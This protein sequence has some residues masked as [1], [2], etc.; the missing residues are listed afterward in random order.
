VLGILLWP[1]P[2]LLVRSIRV[3]RHSD[4]R[5]G[6]GQRL[7][8]GRSLLLTAATVIVAQLVMMAIMTMTPAC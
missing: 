7:A 4:W 8:A 1:D 3:R 2:L 5:A 6:V